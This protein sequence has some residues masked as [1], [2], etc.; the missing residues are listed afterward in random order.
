MATRAITSTR[1]ST[2]TIFGEGF[3]HGY[4]DGFNSRY[5]Y[6]QYSNGSYIVLEVTLG[7]ILGFQSLR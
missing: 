6:G 1:T 2:T 4:E 3:R 5:Q 7:Q